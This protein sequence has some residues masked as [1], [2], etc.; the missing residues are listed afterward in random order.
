MRLCYAD[1]KDCSV[2]SGNLGTLGFAEQVFVTFPSD[3]MMIAWADC[4]NDS[5]AIALGDAWLKFNIQ[6]WLKALPSAG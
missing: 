2:I 4:W 5:Q 6:N 3:L 1:F